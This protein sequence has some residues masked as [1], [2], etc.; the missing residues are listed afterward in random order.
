MTLSSNIDEFK[1]RIAKHNGFAKPSRYDI[2]LPSI[3]IGSDTRTLNAICRKVTFPGKNINTFERKTTQKTIQ[4]PS[5]Y[6]ADD[7][8]LTFTETADQMVTK[9]FQLW[10][11]MIVSPYDYLLSY[12]DE[13]CR[14]IF[15]LRLNEQ[16]RITYAVLLK[17]AYPKS[18]LGVDYSAD[19][20]D[21]VQQNVTLV[22]EDYDVIPVGIKD[23]VNELIAATRLQNLRIPLPFIGGN[24]ST[25]LGSVISTASGIIN[26]FN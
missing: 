12:R 1:G 11:D 6:I 22:Y 8:S 20:K 4:T 23:A 13:I 18:I 25:S 5:S 7:V 14:N 16:D 10:M 3:L 26:V 24:A 19:G 17:K 9:Y 2:I 15:I 21:F